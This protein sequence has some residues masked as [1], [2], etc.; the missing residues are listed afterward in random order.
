MSASIFEE[1]N[2]ITVKNGSVYEIKSQIGVNQMTRRISLDE[3]QFEVKGII[4][5]NLLEIVE[6]AMP[7]DYLTEKLNKGIVLVSDEIFSYFT[8]MG[9]QV[10][11]RIR[12]GENG[13]VV[14]G[15][16]FT[17]ESLPE[18][19]I[20]YS[21]V[22]GWKTGVLEKFNQL[23]PIN[24]D[25]WMQFGGNTTIGKGITQVHIYDKKA[26]KDSTEDKSNIV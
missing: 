16:L 13:V 1:L 5:S 9:T 22:E 3:F 15:A 26:D 20:L 21:I 12:I 6:G 18:E 19:S 14:D 24:E 4:E 10:D 2:A 7:S 25:F 11:T 17:E 23:F 8:E